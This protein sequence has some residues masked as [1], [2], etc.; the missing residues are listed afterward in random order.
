MNK[1]QLQAALIKAKETSN[2]RNFKQTFDLIINLRGL[3]KKK[4]DH[5]IETF[6]TLPFS[7]GRKVKACALIGAELEPQ[8]KGTFDTVILFDHFEKYKDK[9]D[10][11]KLAAAHDFFIAQANIM[12]KVATVFGKVLGPRGKM[13]NPKAG[14]VVAPNANL[15]VVYERFQKTIRASNKLNPAIQCPI[16]NEDMEMAKLIDNGMTVYNSILQVLPNEKHNVKDV[17]VKLTMS[18]PVRI[19][20]ETEEAIAKKSKKHK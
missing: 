17:M 4:Q 13:P 9:K 3:D 14:G 19:G 10:I 2:K 20:E 1:E 8:A 12:P 11:K 5:Q 18:K 6:I 15:K 16:G 7:R